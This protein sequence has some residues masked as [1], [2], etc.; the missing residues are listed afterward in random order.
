MV[1]V[2]GKPHFKKVGGIWRCWLNGADE[3]QPVRVVMDQVCDWLKARTTRP[4]AYPQVF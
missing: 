1:V 2:E 4:D 3:R